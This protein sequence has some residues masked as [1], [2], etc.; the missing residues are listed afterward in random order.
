MKVCGGCTGS[1]KR[2]QAAALVNPSCACLVAPWPTRSLGGSREEPLN[3]KR[4]RPSEANWTYGSMF[5]W[6][7]H[8]VA[9][10]W[11]LPCC[12]LEKPEHLH[13]ASAISAVWTMA[14]GSRWPEAKS[15]GS[16]KGKDCFCRKLKSEERVVVS[17]RQAALQ[18]KPPDNYKTELCR[19]FE[20][21]LCEPRLKSG[22]LPH[23]PAMQSGS[24]GSL[25]MI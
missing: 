24:L 8:Y 10:A 25:N 17:V 9:Q 23:S 14:K 21:G 22:I 15:K 6:C 4:A 12:V 2:N 16:G 19:F 11:G 18:G 5:L 13:L 7:R 1:N 20:R 3:F